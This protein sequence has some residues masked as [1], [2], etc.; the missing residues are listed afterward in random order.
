M[1]MTL[2]IF[3][4]SL[5]LTE[6]AV[7]HGQELPGPAEWERADLT[8]TRLPPTAFASLPGALQSEL[9]RRGCT[10]PQTYDGGPPHNVIQGRFL[11]ASK[12]DWA[13]LCSRNRR[14]LILV[15]WEGVATN[16]SELAEQPDSS[17]LQVTFH[18]TIGFSRKL[19]VATPQQIREQH[20]I[21]GGPKPPPLDHDGVEDAF[22][23]KA[24]VVWYRHGSQW[25]Q[26]TGAD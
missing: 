22:L 7:S 9:H 23:D 8:T 2:F 4:L 20:R 11:N 6:P 21:F 19:G 26:L 1:T 13:V 16:V 25:L 17:Y 14:S 18:Q 5:M 24:S 12:T 10:V 15:F 3:F